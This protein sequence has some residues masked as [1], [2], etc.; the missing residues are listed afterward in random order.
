MGGDGYN[1]S[2]KALRRIRGLVALLVVAGVTACASV[3]QR[4]PV[5]EAWAETATIPGIP[6][7]RFWGD[8]IPPDYEERLEAA[9]ARAQANNPEAMR[10]A[11]AFLA[12][13]G[14]GA[15]GAFGAGLL[16][17][18]TVAGPNSPW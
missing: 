8:G 11:P 17:G 2:V 4:N 7:A 18:W 16:N 1:D 3:P 5:P 9:R 13:S 15:N 6:F 12:V 14:G 10:Q